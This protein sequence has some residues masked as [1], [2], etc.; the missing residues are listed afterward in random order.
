MPV[1]V[2]LVTMGFAVCG[3][4]VRVRVEF[5]LGFSFHDEVFR[6]LKW[7]LG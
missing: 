5:V 7:R 6:T 3:G 1:R 2:D 4:T